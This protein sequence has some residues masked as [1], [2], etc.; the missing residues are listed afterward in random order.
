MDQLKR[1]NERDRPE[2]PDRR[3]T[4][5]SYDV[6]MAY[7]GGKDSSYTLKILKEKYGLKILALT[8]DNGFLSSFALENIKRVCDSLG[9]DRIVV[10]INLPTLYAAYRGS[11][12]PDLYPIKALE[13]ASSICNTCMNLVK[14]Y[15][16]KTGIEMGIPFLAYGWSPGQAPLSSSIMRWNISMIKKTQNILRQQFKR[17]LRDGADLLTLSDRHFQMLEIYERNAYPPFFYNIHPLAFLDYDEDEI[18]NTIK[19]LGWREPD[20]TDANS[21]NCLLNSLG[22]KIHKEQFGFHPYA[23]EIANLVR[24]GYMSREEG[25]EKLS[26]KLDEKIIRQVEE[27]LGLGSMAEK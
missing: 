11:M 8:F 9:I 4:V 17:I 5:F 21:T 24:E 1:L 12:N 22:I 18:L 26:K 2:N 6:L 13:R 25:L 14:S 3:D 20:D 19:S 16:L 10:S 27:K 7:S 23:F 15:M